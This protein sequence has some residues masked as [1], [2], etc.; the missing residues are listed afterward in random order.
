[1]ALIG[2]VL[3]VFSFEVTAQDE[4]KE[5]I[6]TSHGFDFYRTTGDVLDPIAV[7]SRE[8]ITEIDPSKYLR[9]FN[10]GRVSTLEDG[11]VVREFTIISDDRQTVEVSSGVFYNVWTFNGTVPGPTLR[12][13]EGDLIRDGWC[14]SKY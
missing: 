4:S 13:S 14:L 12:A 2:S 3:A 11:T 10:Y 9:S 6:V 1:M 8:S 5:K 7:D